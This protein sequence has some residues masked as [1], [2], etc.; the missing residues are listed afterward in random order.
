MDVYSAPG[1]TAAHAD[2]KISFPNL[3]NGFCRSLGT[4][5][6]GLGAAIA[7]VIPGGYSLAAFLGIIAAACA[8]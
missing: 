4:A 2:I 3:D 6:V 8:F 1:T 5:V 7:G